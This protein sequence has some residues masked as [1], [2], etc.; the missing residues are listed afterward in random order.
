MNHIPYTPDLSDMNI[1]VLEDLLWDSEK[2]EPI[3]FVGRDKISEFVRGR[4]YRRRLADGKEP[5]AKGVFITGAPGVGKTSLLRNIRNT[6]NDDG[7]SPVY[8][9]GESLSSPIYIVREVFKAYFPAVRVSDEHQWQTQAPEARHRLA[10]GDDI[11]EIIR[12]LLNPNPGHKFLFLIDESQR[13]SRD[14]FGE[15]N[16]FAAQIHDGNTGELD[17]V[18]VFAGLSDMPQRLDAVGVSRPSDTSIRMQALTYEESVEVVI[19]FLDVDRFGLSNAFSEGGRETIS[20]TLAVASEGWPRHL[21][22]YLQALVKH[23]VEDLK[24]T[25]PTGSIDLESI[26]NYGDQKRFLYSEQRYSAANLDMDYAECLMDIAGTVGTTQTFSMDAV[27]E[28]ARSH[29]LTADEI[30]S[31]RDKALHSGLFEDT[32]DDVPGMSRPHRFA[33]P[34]TQSY[35]RCRGEREKVLADLKVLFDTRMRERAST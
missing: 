17:V 15:I 8:L 16:S 14:R 18:P 19:K 6:F 27:E 21:H 3:V 4:V 35:L 7:V 34:S 1:K 11:W 31:C 25:S 9:S 10:L 33:I 26:V 29:N 28:L 22:H 23:L 24:S 5:S 13:I 30:K 20:R 2:D 12:D 32:S